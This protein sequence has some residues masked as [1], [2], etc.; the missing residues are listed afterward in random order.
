[1]DD[2]NFRRL[3]D[4]SG[5]RKILPWALV[6]PV[7]NEIRT[8]SIEFLLTG[9]NPA[10]AEGSKLFP[11]YGKSAGMHPPEWWGRVSISPSHSP[12][13]HPPLTLRRFLIPIQCYYSSLFFIYKLYMTLFIPKPLKNRVDL[14]YLAFRLSCPSSQDPE[15]TP[16]PVL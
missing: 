2:V 16:T 3:T 7:L 15:K 4:D 10:F 8:R 11:N 6:A 12:L 5:S 13:L 1:M 14:F 9:P